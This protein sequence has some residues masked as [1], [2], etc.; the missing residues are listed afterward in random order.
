MDK[1]IQTSARAFIV[2]TLFAFSAT[3]LTPSHL[4]QEILA[5]QG[6]VMRNSARERQI[7]AHVEK[8]R[9]IF[10]RFSS[11]FSWE[12]EER[13]SYFIEEESRRYGYEPELILAMISTESSFQHWAESSVGA[14]G[15]MQIYPDT[16]RELVESNRMTWEGVDPLFD[17]FLN[18][19]LGIQ[20]LKMLHR[21][22]GD[23]RLALAAYN[24][25]PNRVLRLMNRAEPVPMDYAE[26]VL[27]EYQNYLSISPGN[28]VDPE[29]PDLKHVDNAYA[30]GTNGADRS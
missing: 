22:F 30:A 28:A 24:Q 17:P 2:C 16:G 26:K 4:P 11:G 29:K 27:K 8:I 10:T 13:L 5:R 1:G 14:V 23:L 21:R 7:Q 15:L 6:R 25:G 9:R 20:Y 18:I 3:D 12:E 19:H